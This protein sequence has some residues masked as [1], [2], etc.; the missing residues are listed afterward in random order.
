MKKVFLGIEKF[1]RVEIF[2]KKSLWRKTPQKKSMKEKTQKQCK[3]NK[4]HITKSIA[5]RGYIV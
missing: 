2:C 1:C 3:K 5:M 4:P